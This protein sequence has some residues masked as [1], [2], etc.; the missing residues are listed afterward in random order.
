MGMIKSKDVFL[1]KIDEVRVALSKIDVSSE[2]LDAL[3]DSINNQELLIPVIGDFSSGKSSLLNNF[4][5][6]GKSILPTA[7]TPE[8]SLATE[9]RYDVNER[10]E[11]IKGNSTVK[12]YSINSFKDINRNASDYSYL[13]VYIN[14]ENLKSI[15]PLV[16]V[17]MPGFQSPVEEHNKAIN[18]Y[19]DRGAYF[20]VLVSA[21][22]GSLHRSSFRQIGFIQECG[23]DF[24]LIVSKSNLVTEEN[25]KEICTNVYNQVEKELGISKNVVSVGKDGVDEFKKIITNINIE[26]LFSNIVSPLFNKIIYDILSSVNLKLAT[27]DRSD[28]ENEKIIDN[29]ICNLK[30]LESKKESLIKEVST[31]SS[32]EDKAQKIL[33]DVGNDL[34][35]NIDTLVSVAATQGNSEFQAEIIDIIQGNLLV[36]VNQTISD[37]SDSI[38]IR[39][40]TEL[41]NS[42]T[43]M[44][45]LNM[46]NEKIQ[47]IADKLCVLKENKMQMLNDMVQKRKMSSNT[48][49]MYKAVTTTLGITTSVI[50]PLVEMVIIF[51]PDIINFLKNKF[52]QSQQ[53]KRMKEYI[54]KLRSQILTQVIPNIKTKLRPK[55]LNVLF[56][57]SNRLVEQ[58]VNNFSSLLESKRKEI[59]EAQMERKQYIDELENEIEEIKSVK[60]ILIE[61]LNN[62]K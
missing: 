61:I 9:L 27:F 37:L 39:L 48:G 38:S 60:K 49:M 51:L 20:I 24:S 15:Q 3:Q 42:G 7:I 62:G 21:T 5:E 25:L 46:D 54:D 18:I 43:D 17:D 14:D 47:V 52:E 6:E 33:N 45:V 19:L 12:T 10:I 13:K 23:R 56:E 34:V 31:K 36:S 30:K 4:L 40:S 53:E 55:I 28:R 44:S 50:N 2:M 26:E 57:E 58:I 1:K 41:K 11:A 59:E 32:I 8:T 29:L 35:N 22:E 16:L